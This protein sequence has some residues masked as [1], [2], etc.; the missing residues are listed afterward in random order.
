MIKKCTYGTIVI[1][2][3]LFPFRQWFFPFL[4]I[5]WF[6]ICLFIFISVNVCNDEMI[7]R[8]RHLYEC[9]FLSNFLMFWFQFYEL[10]IKAYSTWL[11]YFTFVDSRIPGRISAFCDIHSQLRVE[12]NVRW[13]CLSVIGSAEK[14]VE[15][16]RRNNDGR[17]FKRT[18]GLVRS[19]FMQN[20]I[21]KFP[22]NWMCAR[23]PAPSAIQV[24][25]GF[26]L[27]LAVRFAWL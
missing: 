9:N 8:W 4:V 2:H 26:V 13:I 23:S 24:R 7:V 6:F 15:E 1:Y 11:F 21:G 3:S 25:H 27:F 22:G 12:A 20:T 16:T 18:R 5:R 10:E 17:A 14:E 19:R